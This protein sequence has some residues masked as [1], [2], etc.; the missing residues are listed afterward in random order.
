MNRIGLAGKK[1]VR[2]FQASSHHG[3]RPKRLFVMVNSFEFVSFPVE[4]R[5]LQLKRLSYQKT[6]VAERSTAG[7][8]ST[9]KSI[10]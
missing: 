6:P 10:S 9:I 8:I 1:F 5:R 3:R 7:E 4:I 2:R